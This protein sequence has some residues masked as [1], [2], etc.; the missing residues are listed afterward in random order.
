MQRE[1]FSCAAITLTGTRPWLRC[2]RFEYSARDGYVDRIGASRMP[3]RS[4]AF[5]SGIYGKIC[6]ELLLDQEL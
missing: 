4:F 2:Q 1:F 3:A 6:A 5:L